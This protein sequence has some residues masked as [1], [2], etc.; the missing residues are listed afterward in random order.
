MTKLTKTFNERFEMFG[1]PCWAFY[2][3]KPSPLLTNCILI[4]R[5]WWWWNWPWCIWLWIKNHRTFVH[6]IFS[7]LLKAMA[8]NDLKWRLLAIRGNK[9]SNPLSGGK[10]RMMRTFIWFLYI[11]GDVSDKIFLYATNLRGMNI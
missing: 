11:K 2:A 6:S 1:A 9:K 5:W 4:L 7:N 8:T 10:L 3:F